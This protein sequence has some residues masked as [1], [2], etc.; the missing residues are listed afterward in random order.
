MAKTDPFADVKAAAQENTKKRLNGDDDY[1]AAHQAREKEINN[2][3][4]VT[5][6][7]PVVEAARKNPAEPGTVNITAEAQDKVN[8]KK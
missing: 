2:M 5:D 4:G 8:K 1:L 7:T 6:G 3:E